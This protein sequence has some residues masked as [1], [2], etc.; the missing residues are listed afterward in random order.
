MAMT[1]AEFNSLFAKDITETA[2]NESQEAIM[3]STFN[4]LYDVSDT[5]E[6]TT[7]YTTTEGTE[8]PSWTDEGEVVN[9]TKLAKGY[10]VSYESREFTQSIAVTYKARLKMKDD[11]ERIAEYAN[12]QKR[13]VIMNMAAFLEKNLC[14]IL[15]Y[16]N[17]TSSTYEILS[18]DLQPIA[19]AS[20]AWKS[21]GAT[22]DNDLGLSAIS[23]AHAQTVQEYAGAFTDANGLPMGLNFTKIF[24]KKGSAAAK[25]AKAVYASKN[26]QGQYT[27]A[28]IADMNI[29]EGEVQVIETRWMTSGNDYVYVADTDMLGVANPLFCEFI[30]RP[31]LEGEFTSDTNLDFTSVFTG[32]V[33][34]GLKNLP[35]NLL[36][37]KIA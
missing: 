23:I 18:P 25:Q 9:K 30:K 19:S 13:S 24:V 7:S 10:K 26:A 5:N 6:Y 3:N 34:Y 31:G 36:Y 32:S 11:T 14:G 27:V 28:N 17:A 33:K 21:T 16:A 29:Y 2:A 37:G 4:K 12:T 35:F 20:H 22:F 8:L 1:I 15:N